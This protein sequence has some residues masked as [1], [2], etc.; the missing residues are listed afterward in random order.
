MAGS[1]AAARSADLHFQTVHKKFIRAAIITAH[2]GAASAEGWLWGRG[3]QPSGRTSSDPP[4]WALRHPTASF[5]LAGFALLLWWWWWDVGPPR[6]PIAAGE[7]LPP[8]SPPRVATSA[9]RYLHMSGGLTGS[10]SGTAIYLNGTLPARKPGGRRRG[11][12]LRAPEGKRGVGTVGH[13]GRGPPR[14]LSCEPAS[15]PHG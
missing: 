15:V 11:L 9:F 13:R 3:W 5:A 6:F 10:N 8:R 1:G 12:A 14:P 4:S 2:P 7:A